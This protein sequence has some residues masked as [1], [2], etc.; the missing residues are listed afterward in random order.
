ML[1]APEIRKRMQGLHQAI[2]QDLQK[3]GTMMITPLVLREHAAIVDLTSQLAEISSARIEQQT[4]TLIKLTRRLFCLTWILVI[5]TAV[6][7]VF[8]FFLVKHG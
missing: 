6:L 3:P 7:V 5:L 8:T 4:A 1:D 2:E